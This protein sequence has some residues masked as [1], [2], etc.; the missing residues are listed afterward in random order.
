MS[1]AKILLE[2]LLALLTGEHAHMSFEDVVRDF[3]IDR[4][5]EKLPNADYSPWALLEHIR[6][7]QE[8]ILDF[9]KNPNY[10]YRK[11]PDDYWPRKSKKATPAD[12]NKTVNG[13]EKDF[14]ELEEMVKNPKTDLYH[15]IPWGEGEIFLREIVTVSNHNAFHM[16]EFAI[17]RQAMGTWG[18]N[19]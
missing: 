5:N 10:V 12:W 3:P 13:F 2:N 15:E 6:L 11:W 19:R 14:K 9:I 7:A 16:G 17:M 4:I 8:D 1:Q 18:K